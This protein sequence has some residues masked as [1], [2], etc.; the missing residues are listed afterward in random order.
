[1]VKLEIAAF[2]DPGREREINEDRIWTQVYEAYEGGS[3]G[4]FIVCDGMGGHLGGECASHWAVETIRKDLAD[5]FY[6]GDPRA[7]VKLK[8]V[9]INAA[10]KGMEITRTSSLTKIDLKV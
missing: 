6:P 5:L 3:V 1:M 7:T 8:E 2:T 4:L 10:I 9:E